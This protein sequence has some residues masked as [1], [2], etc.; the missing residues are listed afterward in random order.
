M[1]L[2]I[3]AKSSNVNILTLQFSP[4]LDL[5]IKKIISWPHKLENLPYTWIQIDFIWN[6]LER[7][8]VL[9]DLPLK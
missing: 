3:M 9:L 8:L 1:F 5:A 4:N 6:E 2:V 7:I